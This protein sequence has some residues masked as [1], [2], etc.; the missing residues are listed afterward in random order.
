MKFEQNQFEINWKYVFPQKE[1]ISKLQL[2][3][4]LNIHIF[5]ILFKFF[6]ENRINYQVGIHNLYSL[7]QYYRRNNIYSNFVGK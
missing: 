6:Y 2:L 3:L 5:N 7:K 1:K 4:I